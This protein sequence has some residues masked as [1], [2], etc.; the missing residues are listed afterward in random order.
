LKK[1]FAD[2]GVR[3][4]VGGVLCGIMPGF[5]GGHGKSLRFMGVAGRRASA[6]TITESSGRFQAP[7]A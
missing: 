1:R 3:F 7:A 2:P 4:G 5:A 6:A